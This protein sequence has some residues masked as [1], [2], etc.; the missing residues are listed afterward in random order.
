M[1]PDLIRIQTE[2]WKK[3]INKHFNTLE[4]QIKD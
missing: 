1:I 2:A 3:K 4:T